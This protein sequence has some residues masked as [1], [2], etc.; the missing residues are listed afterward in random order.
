M[1]NLSEIAQLVTVCEPSENRIFNSP[2]L[3]SQRRGWS[4]KLVFFCLQAPSFVA[5]DSCNSFHVSISFFPFCTRRA[6]FSNVSSF[7]VAPSSISH[8]KTGTLRSCSAK[9][10]SGFRSPLWYDVGSFFTAALTFSILPLRYAE[11]TSSRGVVSTAFSYG[12]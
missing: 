5:L 3:L 2:M 4:P 12:C 11:N 10:A 1:R 7:N 8:F 9:R 6:S